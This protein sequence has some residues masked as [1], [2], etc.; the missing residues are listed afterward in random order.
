MNS[1]SRSNNE[2]IKQ[3]NIRQSVL[4]MWK[5][6]SG[7]SEVDFCCWYSKKYWSQ[8]KLKPNEIQ[9]ILRQMIKKESV[10]GEMSTL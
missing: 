8:T 9:Y 3:I 7:M 4:D 1:Y 5:V 6:K 10:T 2:G